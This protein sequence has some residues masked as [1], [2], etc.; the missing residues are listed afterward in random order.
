MK[1]F[2]QVIRSKNTGVLS[3]IKQDTSYRSKAVVETTNM[4]SCKPA[5]S[6]NLASSA[7]KTLSIMNK[8]SSSKLKVKV[9]RE[10][11]TIEDDDIINYGDVQLPTGSKLKN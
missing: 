6:T 8:S 10:H 11:A 9:K 7:F 3:P 2:P 1:L 4:S 5:R